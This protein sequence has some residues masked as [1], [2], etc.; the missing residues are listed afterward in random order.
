ME[1][2]KGQGLEGNSGRGKTHQKGRVV[3][4]GTKGIESGPALEGSKN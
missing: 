4:P 3:V 2:G 1:I